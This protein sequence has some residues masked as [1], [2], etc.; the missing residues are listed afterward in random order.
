MSILVSYASYHSTM[1]VTSAPNK[2][3]HLNSKT[4]SKSRTPAHRPSP[5]PW[6]SHPENPIGFW[7]LCPQTCYEI[8]DGTVKIAEYLSHFRIGPQECSYFITS[9]SDFRSCDESSLEFMSYPPC[10]LWVSFYF[11]HCDHLLIKSL[12][13][14]HYAPSTF[15]GSYGLFVKIILWGKCYY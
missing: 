10:F 8:K 7:R 13:R 14:I 3:L 15:H 12:F 6:H 4:I 1:S 5:W 11:H 9:S 2:T